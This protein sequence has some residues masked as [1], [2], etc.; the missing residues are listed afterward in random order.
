MIEAFDPIKKNIFFI[1]KLQITL[2]TTR[3]KTK[4]IHETKIKSFIPKK[5]LLQRFENVKPISKLYYILNISKGST[6]FFRLP[7]GFMFRVSSNGHTTLKYD[8][9]I[10]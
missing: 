6:P 1:D 10:F 8:L 9:F 2:N 4:K 3:F 5:L 7:F